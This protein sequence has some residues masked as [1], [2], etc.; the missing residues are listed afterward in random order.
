MMMNIRTIFPLKY[1]V[2]VS[3]FQFLP[4]LVLHCQ[5]A[6]GVVIKHES[7]WKLAYSGDTMPCPS[8]VNTGE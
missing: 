8:F 1:E 2:C 6:F 3:D 7:G 4:V 5:N